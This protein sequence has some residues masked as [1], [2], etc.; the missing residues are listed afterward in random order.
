MT[1]WLDT[2]GRL[3]NPQPTIQVVPLV[4]GQCCVVVDDVLAHPQLLVDWAAS[5]QFKG[6][7]GYPYPGV[8][9]NVPPELSQRV[10]DHFALFARKP[11]GGRRTLDATVR[12][13][14]VSQAPQ[15]LEP[16]QWQ[17]HRDRVADDPRA[18][19]FAASVLYLFDNPA[20]GGTSF[21]QPRQ[22]SDATDQMLADSQLLDAT[23]FSA[24]YGLQPGYMAGSNAYFERIGQV[25][26]RWNRAIFYDGGLFHSADVDETGPLSADV[27]RGRLTLNS[28]FSCKRNAG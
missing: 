12:L 25:A 8:V 27:G 7:V 22:S 14:V 9:A 13:S 11:L 20:L 16:R 28:F 1:A 24:R 10:A 21:Y 23:T 15:T 4:D 2:T 19:L 26:A 5:Q 6:P 3:F 18:M 17:C